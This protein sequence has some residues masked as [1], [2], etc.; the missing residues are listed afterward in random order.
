MK[1]TKFLLSILSIVFTAV[2]LTSCETE[3][4]DELPPEQILDETEITTKA[5]IRSENVYRYYSGG[6]ASLHTYKTQSGVG[7]GI[8]RR[9]GIAFRTPITTNPDLI[10][11][12][13]YDTMYFM[14]HPQRK[15]F[16]LVT[17]IGEFLNLV[18]SGWRD[19]SG[20]TFVLIHKRPG[21]GR[22]KLYRFY[23]PINSDHLFTKSYAEGVNAGLIYEGV[24]G[25]VY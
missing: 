1:K 7:V 4:N 11:D 8:G 21:N 24:T 23:N 5:S 10:N 16:V 17:D 2:I 15:D 12:S 9:E 3:D 19:V 6:S 13:V 20:R 25:W 22:K 14:L 18:N